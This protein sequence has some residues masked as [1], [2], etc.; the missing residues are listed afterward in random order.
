MRTGI[1]EIEIRRSIRQ[2]EGKPIPREVIEKIL[3][4]GRFAPSMQNS[5]PWRYVILQNESKRIFAQKMKE[6]IIREESGLAKLPESAQYTAD[7]HDTAKI[8]QEAPVLICVFRLCKSDIFSP[9]SGDARVA[10]IC[11]VLS[12]GA[13]IENILLQATCLGVG[14]LWIGNTCFAY[15]ELVDYLHS[16]DQLLCAIALG[17]S[18]ESPPPRPRKS[19]AQIVSF[20]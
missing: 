3:D 4:A 9:V 2:F 19:L 5:Q 10:E 16:E 20:M 13:S 17:Y 6:G 7:A 11:N 1:E 14:S 8:I 12:I 15:K 18:A